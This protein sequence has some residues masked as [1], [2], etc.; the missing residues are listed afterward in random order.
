MRSV[1][2]ISLL[3]TA[4]A[5]PVAAQVDEDYTVTLS[6][7][8]GLRGHQVEVILSLD[9]SSGDPVQ[10]WQWGVCH[11][12]TVLSLVE[13]DVYTTDAFDDLGLSFTFTDV[14]VYDE[15]GGEAGWT[16]G[17]LLDVIYGVTLPPGNYEMFEMEY[18]VLA[19]VPLGVT[20]IEWCDNLGS[21][22]VRVNVVSGSVVIDPLTVDG[23]VEVVEE[24]AF[25]RG[26]A[27]DDGAVT[28]LDAFYI[29]EAVFKQGPAIECAAAAD[30]TGATPGEIGVVD[31]LALLQYLYLEAAAPP[32]PFPACGSA[33]G[34][35]CAHRMSCL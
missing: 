27:D 14:T 26:D 1:V 16:G 25:I 19:D 23:S 11:D 31:V 22:S 9:S 18:T 13:D 29:V 24:F 17:Y 7:T 28:I 12:N 15:P 6:N 8:A 10:A 33:E 3:A 34:E 5:G 35:D 30:L 32:A 2:L 20:A 21:P 4:F